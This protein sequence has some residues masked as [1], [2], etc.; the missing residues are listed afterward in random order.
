MTL[1]DR[2]IWN[3]SAKYTIQILTYY[4]SKIRWVKSCIFLTHP[5]PSQRYP[6]GSGNLSYWGGL[7][8]KKI[9]VSIFV[10]GIS[11]KMIVHAWGL[12]SSTSINGKSSF[13]S[14]N[15]VVL[16]QQCAVCPPAPTPPAFF[17]LLVAIFTRSCT[18][19]WYTVLYLFYAPLLV[20]V[21]LLLSSVNNPRL[22]SKKEIFPTGITFIFWKKIVCQFL[23]TFSVGFPQRCVFPHVYTKA[24]FPLG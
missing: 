11:R 22:L 1:D 18:W 12:S 20:I 7:V 9:K 19:L 5:P 3:K 2:K 6:A 13:A 17:Y 15:F 16:F 21:L 23:Y 10:P 24:H 8:L 14:F 4:V